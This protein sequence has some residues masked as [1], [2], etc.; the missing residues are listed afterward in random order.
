MKMP[1]WPI[2]QG[3]RFVLKLD[4]MIRILEALSNPHLNLP[5]VVHIAG[6]N[7]KG[8]TVAYLSSI[9]AQSGYHYHRYISPHLIYFN[10]R[11]GIC[12]KDIDDKFL[13]QCIDCCR[14]LT[15]NLPMSF[16]EGTTGIAFYAFAKIPADVLILEVGMGGRFDATNV[17]DKPAM[18]IITTISKDHTEYLGETLAEIAFE[19]AGII[20]SGC[21]CVI[22]WQHDEAMAVLIQKC[23]EVSAPVLAWNRDWIFKRTEDGLEIEICCPIEYL[24]HQ[25]NF[26]EPMI[27]KAG[28]R[29]AT[30][31]LKVAPPSLVGLHQ[32]V[33]AAAVV[34]ASWWLSFLGYEKLTTT[35][36][37]KG[38]TTAI[39]PGRMQK[40]TTGVLG[41]KLPNNWDLWLDGAHNEAGA[42]MIAASL[43]HLYQ[44]DIPLY[45]I[46]GRTG[47]RDIKGF[48][49]YFTNARMVC[50]VEV[51]SEPSAEKAENIA[52]AANKMGLKSCVAENLVDAVD[53]CLE[54]SKAL[55]INSGVILIC[56][57]LYL[58][59]DVLLANR[60]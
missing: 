39:W 30:V 38:I 22:G 11:I 33:N 43:H 49:R 4:N 19:K 20:K 35:T 13:N 29:Y 48:L 24:K 16:F 41:Q 12:N 2:P 31:Q 47:N 7:G 21:P 57:S 42:E 26:L 8:S 59:G 46:N 9:F 50:G 54:D 27:D 37:N 14:R 56:G 44:N 51:K 18:S 23:D 25:E 40:I 15:E 5:P 55:G 28:N 45:I 36:I 6:T 58:A 53:K 10:E 34:V 32:Y 52:S 3:G 60:D 17:I 1:K